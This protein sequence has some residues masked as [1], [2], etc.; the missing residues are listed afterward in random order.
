MWTTPPC[1]AL[2]HSPYFALTFHRFLD[3][4]TS[5]HMYHIYIYIF[6]RFLN[7]ETSAKLL[8]E[9]KIRIWDGNSS[10][11][12]LDSIGLTEREEG[13]LA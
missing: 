2:F 7:G 6:R 9:K 5:P 10:R 12:Y 11:E 13:K 4:E 3:G 1:L 8:Q